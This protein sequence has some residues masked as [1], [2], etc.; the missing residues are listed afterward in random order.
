MSL[1]ARVVCGLIWRIVLLWVSLP[2]L[3]S[4]LVSFWCAAAGGDHFGGSSSADNIEPNN[5]TESGRKQ[6]VHVCIIKVPGTNYVLLSLPLELT[7]ADSLS[8]GRYGKLI[9]NLQSPSPV[10]R[11]SYS[12]SEGPPHA[13]SNAFGPTSGHL[14]VYSIRQWVGI[15]FTGIDGGNEQNPG[16]TRCILGIYTLWWTSSI[17]SMTF[18]I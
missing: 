13:P 14:L 7:V 6:S 9:Y 18:S 1:L 11:S 12:V 10:E 16:K 8:S 5:A 17:N 4:I 15:P 3:W 2:I